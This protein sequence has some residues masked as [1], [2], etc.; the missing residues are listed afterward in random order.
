MFETV[1]NGDSDTITQE[2]NK[3]L[4]KTISYHDYREDFYHVLEFEDEYDHIFC[5]G[6]S[7]FKKRCIVK[8]K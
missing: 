3:L 6:I 1:W 5:Y 4:R 2:I 8:K 7:F